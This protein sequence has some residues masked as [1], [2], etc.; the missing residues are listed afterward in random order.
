MVVGLRVFRYL[1]QSVEISVAA[2]GETYT[3][4]SGVP[5]TPKPSAISA[6]TA[7]VRRNLVSENGSLLSL[8]ASR[9]YAK[10]TATETRMVR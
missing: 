2:N 7:V 4:P 10:L 8:Q 9:L 3:V 6:E 1:L 5:L